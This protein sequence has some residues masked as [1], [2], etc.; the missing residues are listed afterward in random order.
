[1]FGMGTGVALPVWSPGKR[2]VVVRAAEQTHASI[3]LPGRG[4]HRD[5]VAAL[6]AT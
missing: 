6:L 5:E 3:L 4:F 2:L 1:V